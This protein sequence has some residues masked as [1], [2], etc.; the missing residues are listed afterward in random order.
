MIVDES[1]LPAP[2][3]VDRRR[4]P[5]VDPFESRR[6]ALGGDR[7]LGFA[8]RIGGFGLRPSGLW[9]TAWVGL[10]GAG[11][12]LIG[13]VTY[14]V[15]LALAPAGRAVAGTR[16]T[17]APGLRARCDERGREPRRRRLPRAGARDLVDRRPRP[18]DRRGLRLRRRG[19]GRVRP[20][21]G[22]GGGQPY[23]VGGAAIAGDRARRRQWAGPRALSLVER[24]WRT[25]SRRELLAAAVADGQ[26]HLAP[27]RARAGGRALARAAADASSPSSRRR[28]FC[29]VRPGDRGR[30]SSQRP[31]PSS[32]TSGPCSL[33]RR[34]HDV[35]SVG[36][37]LA[38]R[39]DGP[40][41]PLSVAR[42]GRPARS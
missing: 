35:R 32:P 1:L 11:D 7:R 13:H 28:P 39:W 6:S 29:P 8:A 27:R 4:T 38:T 20:G 24:C 40:S 21:V 22:D 14:A 18:R 37:S 42:G 5:R 3:R 31:S 34:G 30:Q 23:S 17:H 12:L 41:E 19:D 15:G 26:Q 2:S 36:T 33:T 16:A 10:G 9:P 25:C